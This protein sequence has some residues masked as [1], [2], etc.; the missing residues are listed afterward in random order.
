MSAAW[1][2]ANQVELLINGEDFFPRVF[3][4]IRD[5]LHEVLLE[6]FIIFEDPVGMELQAA[7]I[8]AAERGVRIE[9]TADGYGTADLTRAGTRTR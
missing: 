6:T 2:D 3:Q 9:V 1:R 5:A 7:L 8:A 4:A